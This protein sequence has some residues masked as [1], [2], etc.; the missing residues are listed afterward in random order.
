MAE[1]EITKKSPN[2]METDQDGDLD[3]LILS[4][5]CCSGIVTDTKCRYF[6]WLGYETQQS[7]I[8][9]VRLRTAQ[10]NP[11]DPS[12]KLNSL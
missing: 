7:T 9:L 10:T 5:C 8:S 3:F 11:T 2:K 6:C 12:F 4:L 1:D